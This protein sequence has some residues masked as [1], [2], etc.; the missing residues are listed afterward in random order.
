M[1][2]SEQVAV[3]YKLDK[4]AREDVNKDGQSIRFT[5]QFMGPI[6]EILADTL[7]RSAMVNN[8]H[9]SEVFFD[10]EDSQGRMVSYVYK[11]MKGDMYKTEKTVGLSKLAIK[12]LKKQLEHPWVK[13][14]GYFFPI[15]DREG[16][17]THVNDWLRRYKAGCK[18]YGVKVT[19]KPIH[20]FR[21]TGATRMLA[22]NANFTQMGAQRGAG[23]SMAKRYANAGTLDAVGDAA[24]IIDQDNEQRAA[25]K[26]EAARANLQSVKG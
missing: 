22:Q 9:T 12:I 16:N 10:K 11:K 17:I 5:F 21:A 19:N 1:D 13:K 6:I 4:I 24:R 15:I 3:G 23:I 2:F 18:K 14:S 25:R 8:L 26:Q 7:I 20:G